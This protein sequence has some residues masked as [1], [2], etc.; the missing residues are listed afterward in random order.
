MGTRNLTCVFK[1]GEYKVAQ[2]GQWD[3]YPSGVGADI[4]T[5]LHEWANELDRLEGSLAN[6]DWITDE[7]NQKQWALAG[8]GETDRWVSMEVANKHRNMFP[9]NSRDTGADILRIVSNFVPSVDRQK[10]LLQ[11]TR[12]FAGDSLFCEWAY[13]ID[14]DKGTFEVYEGFN[15]E[16][17]T[18][19][20]RFFEF[21]NPKEKYRPVKLKKAY[22]LNALPTLEQ[23]LK[24]LEPSEGE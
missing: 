6:V 4:L 8:A 16:P 21:D 24:D 14:Y 18:P 22:P 19:M 15:K 1:D 5:F 10:L 23:F 7:E 11:D 3:G 20:E 12:D 17:L 2:Y 9:E 13:V